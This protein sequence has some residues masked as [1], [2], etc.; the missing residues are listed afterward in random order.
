MQTKRSD[1]H[2]RLSI[3]R[4]LGDK[5]RIQIKSKPTSEPTPFCFQMMIGDEVKTVKI[6]R[7]FWDTEE[8]WEPL[9]LEKILDDRKLIERIKQQPKITIK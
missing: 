1:E 6:N 2:K 9:S 5:L 3:E 7:V 4:Y 8:N